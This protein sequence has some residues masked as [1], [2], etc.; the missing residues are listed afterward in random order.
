MLRD[1]LDTATVIMTKGA[2]NVF[3]CAAP[4]IVFKRPIFSVS[5]FLVRAGRPVEELHDLIEFRLQY[6]LCAAVC[7]AAFGGAIGLYRVV[8]ASAAGY[9]LAWG[10]VVFIYQHM[11]DRCS[12]G[13]AQGP[14]VGVC[15]VMYRQAICVAFH[16]YIDV[17]VCVEYTGH[18]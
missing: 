9:Q 5:T 12:T 4:L 7:S 10:H 15:A 3:R 11:R 18:L 2:T 1:I 17:W 13:S 16:I 14:V 8:P 6:Y